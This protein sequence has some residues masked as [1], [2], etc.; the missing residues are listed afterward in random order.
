M[1]ENQPPEKHAGRPGPRRAPEPAP[2]PLEPELG[3]DA[4]EVP[5][6]TSAGPAG[7]GPRP[8]PV[9]ARARPC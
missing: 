2:D 7:P 1:A 3:L 4:G 5:A 6:N 8:R 9:R